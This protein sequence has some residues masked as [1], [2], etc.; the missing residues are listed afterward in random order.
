M[1]SVSKGVLSEWTS[2]TLLMHKIHLALSSQLDKDTSDLQIIKNVSVISD[3]NFLKVPLIS[4]WINIP[5]KCLMIS[6][7]TMLKSS[8][9]IIPEFL[10]TIHPRMQ[11][12]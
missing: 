7:P 4:D 6:G 12:L 10:R 11:M 1:A 2:Y 8:K 3:F 9:I 5:V